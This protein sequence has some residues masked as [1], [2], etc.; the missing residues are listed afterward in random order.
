MK[1][2]SRQKLKNL[3]L[4]ALI[5]VVAV[6]CVVLMVFSWIF[7]RQSLFSSFGNAHSL[8][9]CIPGSV[10][11]ATPADFPPRW[12]MMVP[13]PAIS[14]VTPASLRFAEK[15]LADEVKAY[16]SKFVADNLF[17][18]FICNSFSA[19]GVKYAGSQ[20]GAN[21]WISVGSDRDL[22]L[23]GDE[24]AATFHHEF[25]ALLFVV[26]AKQLDQIAWFA[27][28]PKNKPFFGDP[29]TSIGRGMSS[30]RPNPSGWSD[31]YFSDYSRADLGKD[32]CVLW[33]AA[34]SRTDELIAAICESPKIRTKVLLM[35]SFAEKIGGRLPSRVVEAVV[36]SDR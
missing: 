5:L 30:T 6:V 23:S 35:R 29:F 11:A 1:Y 31:G 12:R 2:A 18:I 24:I 28:I 14:V 34:F 3:K 26:H 4:S 36:T 25:A 13:P 22:E 33:E 19:K 16:D 21:I 7:I 8:I 9:D 20:D 15:I 27:E 10:V 32:F 17:Y